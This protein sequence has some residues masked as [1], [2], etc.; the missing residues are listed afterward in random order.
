MT[1]EELDEEARQLCDTA[2]PDVASLIEDSITLS[3]GLWDLLKLH[4]LNHPSDI[5]DI[6]VMEKTIDRVYGEL[7]AATLL[8]SENAFPG[9]HKIAKGTAISLEMKNDPTVP[10]EIIQGFK[11]LAIRLENAIETKKQAQE[12]LQSSV[13]ISL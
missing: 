1:F 4:G 3:K 7:A 6:A 5:P 8:L 13:K 10:K 2:N 12:T 11:D 9:I